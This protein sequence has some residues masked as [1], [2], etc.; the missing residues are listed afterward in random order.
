MQVEYQ[1]KHQSSIFAF[2]I[3][4]TTSTYVCVRT[5]HVTWSN[6]GDDVYVHIVLII[7]LLHV[8]YCAT[9]IL[10]ITSIFIGL[11]IMSPAHNVKNDVAV[12]HVEFDWLIRHGNNF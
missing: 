10:H 4:K 3:S 8:K 5:V 11:K 6:K 9:N 7:E 2:M 1:N 12:Y